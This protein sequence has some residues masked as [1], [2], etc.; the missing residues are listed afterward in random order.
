MP[1]GIRSSVRNPL[2]WAIFLSVLSRDT[3]SVWYSIK[4]A[5]G[6]SKKVSNKI[7]TTA[8]FCFCGRLFL[9][10]YRR[11]FWAVIGRSRLWS[12]LAC[13]CLSAICFSFSCLYGQSYH[14]F[15]Y[16]Q[17]FMSSYHFRHNRFICPVGECC[18]CRILLFVILFSAN[19]C[20]IVSR[21]L[22]Q[23]AKKRHISWYRLYAG[24]WSPNLTPT[25][26]ERIFD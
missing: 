8:D 16:I 7:R 9:C 15:S 22:T 11:N 18:V 17:S 6:A 14:V 4:K 10:S 19:Y 24:L 21:R 5:S 1:K 23:D 12:R 25:R 3:V 13:L 26:Y 2:S 20:L